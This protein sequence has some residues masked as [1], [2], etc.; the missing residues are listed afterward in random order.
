MV[1]FLINTSWVGSN[2][3]RFGIPWVPKLSHGKEKLEN[4]RVTKEY[5]LCHLGKGREHPVEGLVPEQISITFR[6][7]SEC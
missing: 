3:E 1:Q 4:L 7:V 5:I 6:G 2:C